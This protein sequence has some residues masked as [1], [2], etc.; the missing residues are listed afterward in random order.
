MS[1]Q[2]K[3]TGKITIGV[4]VTPREFE[5]LDKHCETHGITKTELVRAYIRSLP[6]YG[7]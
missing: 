2:S 1:S 6:E 4:K 5:A 3:G 7:Q